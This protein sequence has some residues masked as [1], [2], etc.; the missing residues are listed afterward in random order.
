[1]KK[2]VTIVLA[3]CALFLLAVGARRNVSPW[4]EQT[5]PN[6]NWATW[7]REH[8]AYERWKE[9]PFSREFCAMEMFRWEQSILI[10]EVVDSRMNTLPTFRNACDDSADERL[11]ETLLEVHRRYNEKS[12]TPRERTDGVLN[13]ML[14]ES[15]KQDWWKYRIMCSGSWCGWTGKFSLLNDR[16]G[17]AQ[18]LSGDAFA[19]IKLPKQKYGFD[20]VPL[21]PHSEPFREILIRRIPRVLPRW[22][23][24]AFI[25][26]G[27]ALIAWGLFCRMR[28]IRPGGSSGPGSYRSTDCVCACG[29]R[30]K[31]AKGRAAA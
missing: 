16:E 11:T 29:H 6:P 2:I 8:D 10:G 19:L 18:L 1:M 23:L 9:A 20:S 30:H 31:H 5:K 25:A 15:G 4:E 21:V 17:V 22:W 13:E 28:S 3:L 24:P 27:V 26:N 7:K 14:I 12:G